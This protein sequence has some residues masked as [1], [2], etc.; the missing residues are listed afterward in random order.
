[1]AA[2]F[3]RIIDTWEYM[4]AEPGAITLRED[5]SY[6]VTGDLHAKHPASAT[7]IVTPFEQ[8]LRFRDGLIV[9]GTMVSG[10][11]P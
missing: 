1:V 11:M 7:V 4:R 5:G 3:T 9:H 8:S 10:P 2:L 6:M